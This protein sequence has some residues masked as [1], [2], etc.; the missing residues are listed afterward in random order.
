M[1]ASEIDDSC[2]SVNPA[3]ATVAGRLRLSL[4]ALVSVAAASF[5]SAACRAES[6]LLPQPLSYSQEYDESLSSS[7]PPEEAPSLAWQYAF[8]LAQIR[9]PKAR[10]WLKDA[11]N[12]PGRQIVLTSLQVTNSPPR[13]IPSADTKL[14]IS[15]SPVPEVSL[16]PEAEDPPEEVPAP[17]ALEG[18]SLEAENLIPPLEA[19]DIPLP[20]N[21][22]TA[23]R[24][25]DARPLVV[26]AAQAKAWIAEAQLQRA[27]V[28]WVPEL[29][30]ASVYIRHDGYG[31]DFNRGF[32]WPYDPT[33][34]RIPIN[35][36][37][38][39]FYLGG[40]LNAVFALTDAVFE[41]LAAR[42]VLNARRWDIQVAKN[43]ALLGTTMAY[44]NVHRA[45]GTYAA[46]VDVVARGRE[47][48]VELEALS[49]DL[50]PKVEVERA[51]RL[52]ADLEQQAALSRQAWRESSADLTQTLRLD[53]RVIVDPAERDH[54]QITLI[55]PGRS[56]DEL[57]SIALMSRPELSSQHALIQAAQVRIRQEKLRPFIPKVLVTG[58][59][60]PAGMRM[61][62]G[63]FA[64]GRGSELNLW[65]FRDDVTAQ[66]VWEAEGLG[67]GNSARVK[68]QRGEESLAIKRLYQIQDAVAAEV[69]QGQ[70]R[71]QSAAVR[72]AEA[73]RS[74]HAALATYNG[75][76]EGLGQTRR[77]DNVL[78][79]VYRPQE[80]VIALQHLW[81]AYS[82][83]FGSVADYNIAQFQLFHA[84]GYPAQ[85]VTELHPPGEVMQVDTERP[86]Y[87]PPVTT[88]PPPATR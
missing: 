33:S 36:N 83:Y 8:E 11:E 73:E 62:F 44:F 21:L 55:D 45:R 7:L 78:V 84:L 29:N 67:F 85:E 24:L 41:P 57:L 52:L 87:L 63:V 13:E 48:I 75:C 69:N 31:P 65:S 5:D 2:G 22:G 1:R 56:L 51:R 19:S 37:I 80:V 18:K 9:V 88:G 30:I 23:L 61:Q 82:Q 70:A 42:Q 39:Y 10:V 14:S 68:Q 34:T 20:I 25:S 43:D 74:L 86:G 58:F 26:V 72:V 15:N 60:T 50:I 27:R 66:L 76:K 40:G 59:Q 38:N 12:S 81:T 64:T 32:D 17:K 47:L 54:L 16:P 77:F 35:Q 71:L 46:A 28:I 53:P 49:R 6:F 3:T 79:Q 4:Y